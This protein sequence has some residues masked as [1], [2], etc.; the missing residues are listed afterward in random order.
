MRGTL[1]LVWALLGGLP[2]PGR[3]GVLVVERRS[4]ALGSASGEESLRAFAASR[5]EE[6]GLG[7]RDAFALEAA[8]IPHAAGVVRLRRLIDGL[9]VLNG[10]IRAVVDERGAVRSARASGTGANTSGR[11]ALDEHDAAAAALRSPGAAPLVGAPRVE[12]G[13]WA[14]GASVRAVY[15]VDHATEAAEWS[16]VI[17]AETGRLLF[18]ED[19]RRSVSGRVYDVSPVELAD[20]TVCPGLA[21]CAA[22]RLVPLPNVTS[23][24]ALEGAHVTVHNCRGGDQLSSTAPQPG[25]DR[26]LVS[27]QGGAY[28]FQPAASSA[29]DDFAAVMAY[30]Q[31]DRHFAFLASL[32]AAHAGVLPPVAA[33]VNVEHNGVPFANA[34][35]SPS[36]KAVV[37]GQGAAVD[38]AYD[39]SVAFHELTHGAVWAW[40]GFRSGMDSLGGLDEPAALDEGT[41]D[42]L[43]AAHLGDSRIALYVATEASGEGQSR[44]LENQRTCQGSGAVVSQVG[45]DGVVDGLDGEPHDDGQIWGGFFWEVAQG[46]RGETAWGGSCDG[47]A[48]LQ[49]AALELAAGQSPSLRS[50]AEDMADAARRLVFPDRPEVADFVECVARRRGMDRCDRTFHLYRGE[51]KAQ[52]I[53]HRFGP[54]QY[55]V[56]T[57]G[58]A[59]L[60]FCSAGGIAASAYARKGLPVAVDLPA[61]GDPLVLADVGPVA[62]SFA[63]NPRTGVDLVTLPGAGTWYVLVDAP[64]TVALGSG[65]VVATADG[66]GFASRT[67]ATATASCELAPPR[68]AS[69]EPLAPPAKASGG[70][71]ATGGDA[72]PALLALALGLG[73]RCLRGVSR[74]CSV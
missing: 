71:C 9:P 51:T 24:T 4:D 37:F 57:T 13:W 42:A 41:A 44:D 56:D 25:C 72:L 17:D 27:A 65:I 62:L 28:D 5:A 7:A 36:L 10:A 60:S 68:S 58:P 55:L 20:G 32:D 46:L 47:A 33:Y 53:R 16:S 39:A 3:G 19:R 6:L 1:L 43:A 64:D 59:A 73:A 34:Y 21:P 14:V 8:P 70:G 52:F 23:E 74:R 29:T 61:T 11:F 2:V 45:V 12:R 22:T 31:L 67:V 40:G 15:R 50:Y 26:A 49:F 18:R 54:F 35:F 66:Q 48:A 63:C 69:M 38:Y 30:Y